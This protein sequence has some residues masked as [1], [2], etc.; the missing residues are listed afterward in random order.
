MSDMT[1]ALRLQVI[2]RDGWCV[3]ETLDP[4]AGPCRDKWGELLPNNP[5]PDVWEVDHVKAEPMMGR[6]APSDM[7]HLVTLC[8]FHHQG[9]WATSHRDAERDYLRTLYPE[10]WQ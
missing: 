5:W 4:Q 7:A 10:S 9:G 1:G 8:H 2:F 6:K 3:A